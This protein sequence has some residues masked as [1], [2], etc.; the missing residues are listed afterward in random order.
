MKTLR[1]LV[2]TAPGATGHRL[3]T[4]LALSVA[5]GATAVAQVPT[6]LHF[7]VDFQGPTIARPIAVGAQQYSA[8][9][10][11]VRRGSPF[12]PDAPEV[13]YLG[14]FLQQY[15]NCLNTA[16]GISCGVEV[17]AISFGRD[18]RPRNSSTSRFS[19]YVSTDEWAVG[20]PSPLLQPSVPTIFRE[21]TRRDASS[22]IYVQGFTGQFPFLPVLPVAVGA[23][24][25]NGQSSGQ[26]LA[27][28]P[29]LG[30]VEP[31]TPDAGSA[32]DDGDNID[33]IDLGRPVLQ[34]A[35]AIY[36]SL[37]A[38]FP[39]CNEPGVP[40]ADSAGLQATV[41][42]TQANGA[43]IL[44]F[45][46]NAPG[47]L[48]SLFAAGPQLGLDTPVAGVDDVDA[49][50]IFDNAPV[51]IYTPPRFT[52]PGAPFSWNDPNAT[53]ITDLL[54]FSVRCNSQII[55]TD[56]TSG[57]PITEGDVLIKY[58]GAPVPTIF[59]AAEDLGLDT[60]LRGLF[61]DELDGLDIVGDDEE[62]FEDCNM[63]GIDDGVDIGAMTSDDCDLNGVPDECEMPGVVYCACTSAATA[64]CGN[65]AGAEEGC[66]NALGLGG[67]L[68]GAGTSSI[69]TDFLSLQFSQ[70]P[71][72]QFVLVF[73]GGT[74]T[75]IPLGNGRL[76]VGPSQTRL[77]VVPTDAVGAA[78]YGPGILG[79]IASIGG[80]TITSGS[81][82]GFQGWYRDFQPGCT[83]DPFNF[84]NGLAV[85][86]TP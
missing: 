40:L 36:F 66:M 51:G 24:D 41:L 57:R 52:Q 46:P 18:F 77:Q 63:N 37:Q 48:P 20:I 45:D 15:S 61:N 31:T 7:S 25:G 78:T 65:T 1:D 13:T 35:D 76:C 22:D 42:G 62:P 34:S 26:P 70:L 17:D 27:A 85:T 14:A 83:P 58:A 9:D 38:G 79:Y 44:R 69:S 19:V 21:A 74:A 49:V 30:V 5:T 86:F 54:L 80:P 6:E 10:L 2:R 39:L 12:A 33:A 75:N 4:G 81:T 28:F 56:D 23:A 3:A 8:G 59:I 72:N 47:Q 67:K 50:A 11:L 16:P 29:G 84:T 68:E 43:D 73:V 60:T 53:T 71:A 82:W 64:P 32:A 55:G